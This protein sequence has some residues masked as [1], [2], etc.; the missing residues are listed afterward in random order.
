MQ[1]SELL[2]KPVMRQV[3]GG[4][5][6]SIVDLPAAGCWRLTLTWRQDPGRRQVRDTLDL[7]YG[8]TV[9]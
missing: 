5:G 3:T 6:P 7:A 2:G 8:P 1:G 9:A 4:P